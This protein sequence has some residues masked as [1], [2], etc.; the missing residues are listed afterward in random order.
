MSNALEIGDIVIQ[1]QQLQIR[2]SKLLERLDLLSNTDNKDNKDSKN[3]K[4]T[5]IVRRA[6]TPHEFAIG[7]RVHIKN[8][9]DL[10]PARGTITKI[11]PK[12]IT[13]LSESGINIICAP[14]NL[15]LE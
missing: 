3:N 5:P 2:Q 13:V 12:C 1:L 7:D 14:K 9:R 10:L 11:N 4:S 8:P 15:T 6:A